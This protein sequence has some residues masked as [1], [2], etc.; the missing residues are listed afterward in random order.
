MGLDLLYTIYQTY[1]ITGKTTKGDP[2]SYEF[3]TEEGSELDQAEKGDAAAEAIPGL[4]DFLEVFRD[5]KLIQKYD[6][7]SGDAVGHGDSALK[8]A[9]AT[10]MASSTDTLN[11]AYVAEEE[12]GSPFLKAPMPA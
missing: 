11:K 9:I 1:P 4:N 2:I 3:S 5:F 8:L 10:R 6:T 7:Y 12:N